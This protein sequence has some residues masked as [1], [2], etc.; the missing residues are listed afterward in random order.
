M[1]TTTIE[2]NA[3]SH[4]PYHSKPG[5]NFAKKRVFTTE[6]NNFFNDNHD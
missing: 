3:D 2:Y 1:P 5:F 4:F 6:F